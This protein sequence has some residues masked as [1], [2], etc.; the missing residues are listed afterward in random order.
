M[1]GK[2]IEKHDIILSQHEVEEMKLVKKGMSQQEAHSLV[3][4]THNYAKEP[5]KYYANIKKY[6]K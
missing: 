3:N 1:T 6:K 4:K 5:D 2:N